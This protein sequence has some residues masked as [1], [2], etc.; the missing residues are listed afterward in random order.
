MP[1][2]ILSLI[3]IVT[4]NFTDFRNIKTLMHQFEMIRYI[5]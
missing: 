4:I 2:H 1:L 3:L 5:S